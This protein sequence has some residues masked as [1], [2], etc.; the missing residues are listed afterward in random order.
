[1][2]GL[3]HASYKFLVEIKVDCQANNNSRNSM[4]KIPV[5]VEVCLKQNSTMKIQLAERIVKEV[6]LENEPFFADA[7]ISL[8][9]IISRITNEKYA[10]HLRQHV[11]SIQIVDLGGRI[12][13]NNEAEL[14]VNAYQLNQEGG[15]EEMADDESETAACKQWILPSSDFHGMWDTLIFDDDIKTNLLQYAETTMLFSDRMV[16]S[17]LISWNRCVIFLFNTD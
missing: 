11:E 17:N 10:S 14:I 16:N 7:M 5:H 8:E 4:N 12:V 9:S 3:L 1:M 13:V 6:L 15:A 2:Y